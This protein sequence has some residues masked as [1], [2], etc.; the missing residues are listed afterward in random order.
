MKSLRELLPFLMRVRKINSDNTSFP[1]IL[2]VQIGSTLRRYSMQTVKMCIRNFQFHRSNDKEK[3]NF[4]KF[5]IF[6]RSEL[7][8]LVNNQL[9]HLS[10]RT[11]FLMFNN[12]CTFE[13]GGNSRDPIFLIDFFVTFSHSKIYHAR[14]VKVTFDNSS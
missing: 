3:L 14:T 12:S 5:V 9:L 1:S 8:L 6:K 10:E 2:S 4:I 11:P 7:H 13:E